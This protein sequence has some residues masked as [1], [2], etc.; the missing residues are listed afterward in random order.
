M[1]WRGRKEMKGKE[2]V[3][4]ERGWRERGES[5]GGINFTIGTIPQL[6]WTVK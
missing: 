6:N 5:K 1:S 4:E 3:I 2:G